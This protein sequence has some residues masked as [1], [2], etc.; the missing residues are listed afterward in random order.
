MLMQYITDGYFLFCSTEGVVSPTSVSLAKWRLSRRAELVN[1][2]LGFGMAATVI[3]RLHRISPHTNT[4]THHYTPT[5]PS[6]CK[7]PCGHAAFP[8]GI[9]PLMLCKSY[10]I[11][12][13]TQELYPS[14][15]RCLT[16]FVTGDFASW[17]VHFVNIRVKPTNA[18][19][20]HSVY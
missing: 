18:T 12:P 7:L 2:I 8:I 10:F 14:A 15:Q 1:C 13:L 16:R 19:I 5:S 20:I 6:V 11:D 3:A 9:F 17:T 4:H